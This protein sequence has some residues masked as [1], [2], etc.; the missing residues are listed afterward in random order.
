MEQIRILILEDDVSLRE[1]LAELVSEQGYHV[2]AVGRGEE[3]VRRAM[4]T[5]FDLV[6]TDIRMEGMS[7]LDALAQMK[8]HQPDIGS[9]VVTGYSTEA[10]S[11]RAIR[12]GVGEYLKKPFDLSDFLNAIEALLEKRRQAQLISATEQT[13]ER[14]AR[15][16]IETL[17]AVADGSIQLELPEGAGVT[18]TEAADLCALTASGMALP[19]ETAHQIRAACLATGIERYGTL[20]NDWPRQALGPE[21]DRIVRHSSERWD[22]HG[23]PDGLAEKAIPVGSRIVAAALAL[24]ENRI[25][26]PG[27]FDP[28]VW[29]RVEA[30]SQNVD[31]AQVKAL[32]D[33]ESESGRRRRGLLSLGRALEEALQLDGARQAFAR[34]IEEPGASREAVEAHLGMA[35]LSRLAGEPQSLA[36]SVD[37]ALDAARLM[38]PVTAGWTGLRGGLLLARVGQAKGVTLLEQAD[39]LLGELRIPSGKALTMLAL[40]RFGAGDPSKL[41]AALNV[42]LQPENLT[43]MAENG[44]WLIPHLLELHGNSP[45]P[46]VER[47]LTR[48]ARDCATKFQSSLRGELSAAARKAAVGALAGAGG[49]MA[50]DSLRQLTSDPDSAVRQAANEALAQRTGTGS[51]PLLRIYSMGGFEVYYGEERLDGKW[52]GKQLSFLLAFLAAQGDRAVPE[53][54]MIDAF[55]PKDAIKGRKNLSAAISHLR[56][57]LRPDESKM[58]PMARSTSG[59]GLN[60]DLPRWHDLDELNRQLEASLAHEKAGDVPK[61]LDAG[62]QIARLYRGP[63]LEGCYM[64]WAVNIRNQV[65]R[66]VTEALRKLAQGTLQLGHHQEALEYSHQVLEL[67]PCCQEAHLACMHAYL[68]LGRPEQ[69]VRQ[70]EI[71]KKRL[72]NELGM[73]PSIAILEAHQRALL[74]ID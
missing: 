15:W 24:L 65:E 9:L 13:A 74:S 58:D 60:P 12:L 39:R 34:V 4:E 29:A 42:L 49:H 62:R 68:G 3:A 8:Q 36:D 52:R 7:G 19:H 14:V 25:E 51:A 44:D 66:Q 71:C 16:A 69:A 31:A 27:E 10:D 20:G 28:D 18:L 57:H 50:E 67:D 53:D 6:V 37:R 32:E 45:T 5:P 54:L 30:A 47:A 70:Y 41:E 43:D 64:E 26:E 61:M 48:L 2:E 63:Y 55:W 38:G 46:L 59:M 11:I 33:A 17:A 35:R 40:H 21:I 56:R 73:E 1:M 22:G 23:Q 72:A